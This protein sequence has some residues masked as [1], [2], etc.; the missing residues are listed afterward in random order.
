MA[1]KK[2]CTSI[3]QD[4]IKNRLR[5]KTQK[6]IK[7]E[8]KLID[9]KR[10][11]QLSMSFSQLNQKSKFEL[12]VIEDTED[13]WLRTT[14]SI[15]RS[16][17]KSNRFY[18]ESFLFSHN[19]NLYS[20]TKFLDNKEISSF[21]NNFDAIGITRSKSNAFISNSYG[22]KLKNISIETSENKLLHSGIDD[23]YKV[24]SSREF[25]SLS[26]GKKNLDNSETNN[27]YQR[28]STQYTYN[29]NITNNSSMNAKYLHHYKN[30][31]SISKNVSNNQSMLN[32]P[33]VEIN[34]YKN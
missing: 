21:S 24:V 4:S 33:V 12:D 5:W 17:S 27:H 30:S 7:K 3:T 34:M 13:E 23:A 26:K 8:E 6:E 18:Y 29:T 16:K 32:S 10:R 15:Q 25:K 20:S 2:H 28:Y 1:S 22:D 9:K 19:E 11:D 31:N 14:K